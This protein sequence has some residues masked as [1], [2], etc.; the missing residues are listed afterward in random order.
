VGADGDTV[1]ACGGGVDAE[2]TGAGLAVAGRAA[3]TEA[4]ADGTD[5]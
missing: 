2:G 3:P 4:D 1:W 5:V